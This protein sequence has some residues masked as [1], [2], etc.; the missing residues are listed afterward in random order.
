MSPIR[1][2][3]LICPICPIG[4]IPSTPRIISEV[5]DQIE[6]L[7]GAFRRMGAKVG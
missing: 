1:L 2:I 6:V 7:A 3:C 5:E 4:P